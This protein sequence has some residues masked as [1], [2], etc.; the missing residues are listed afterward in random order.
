M[1]GRTGALTARAVSLT[2]V[3]RRL[4]QCCHRVLWWPGKQPGRFLD[5]R[6]QGPSS[7]RHRPTG[8][9]PRSAPGFRPAS[10]VTRGTLPASPL[11]GHHWPKSSLKGYA[12]FGSYHGQG[13]VQTAHCSKPDLAQAAGRPQAL[14]TNSSISSSPALGVQLSCAFHPPQLRQH[15]Q[16]KAALWPDPAQ[17]T[18]RA[19]RHSLSHKSKLAPT[20]HTAAPRYFS[21]A[22][23]RSTKQ[24]HSRS[25]GNEHCS[26][27]LGTQ[28]VA[29]PSSLAGWLSTQPGVPTPGMVPLQ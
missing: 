19:I 29:P 22:A 10:H 12:A 17:H 14:A 20:R 16:G 27:P 4:R 24:P 3:L 15:R 5:R 25:R 13:L 28:A 9:A 26:P 23:K 18:D 7:H 11:R 21:S 6:P 2:A 1:P 8:A